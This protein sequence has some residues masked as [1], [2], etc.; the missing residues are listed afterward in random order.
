MRH[1][2]NYTSFERYFSRIVPT[3]D[4]TLKRHNTAMPVV[5]RMEDEHLPT[6]SAAG[7]AT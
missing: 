3:V 6:E 2:I 7:Q 5:R 4:V 1:A